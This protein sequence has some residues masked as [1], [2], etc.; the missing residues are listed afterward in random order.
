[1]IAA[2]NNK[3]IYAVSNDGVVRLD[4]VKAGP[5]KTKLRGP[6][7]QLVSVDTKLINSLRS[8]LVLGSICRLY[9]AEQ[10]A[11]EVAEA[12]KNYADYFGQRNQ[13]NFHLCSEAEFI[14]CDRPDRDPDFVSGSGSRYWYVD[15]G[16]VRE[17]DHW[18]PFVAS[19]DWALDGCYFND[20]QWRTGFCAFAGFKANEA[21]RDQ[22]ARVEKAY[23]WAIKVNAMLGQK[24]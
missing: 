4:I 13:T 10:L 1:M 20:G 5:R 19:C 12:I 6:L 8:T 18:L 9:T 16:V 15:G 2:T 22:L 14:S 24:N 11:N 21:R 17:S 7:G 23:D 3:I